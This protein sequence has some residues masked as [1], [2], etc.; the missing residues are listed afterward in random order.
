MYGK[1]F[2]FIYELE[3]DKILY[4]EW[5][6]EKF[7]K[8]KDKHKFMFIFIS[9]INGKTN[10][11]LNFKQVADWTKKNKFMYNNYNPEIIKLNN[12]N[13]FITELNLIKERDKDVFPNLI[14]DEYVMTDKD[15]LL[16]MYSKKRYEICNI[17]KGVVII[18]DEEKY[19]EKC[20]SK[21]SKELL[22]YEHEEKLKI[23]K[24]ENQVKLNRIKELDPDG[25]LSEFFNLI[26]DQ[27]LKS[28][29]NKILSE[30]EGLKKQYSE[31]SS[32]FLSMSYNFGMGNIKTQIKEVVNKSK[33][34]YLISFGNT[35]DL[36]DGCSFILKNSDKK[37]NLNDYQ[38]CSYG[39]T[40]NINQTINKIH[41]DVKSLSN[42]DLKFYFVSCD[43]EILKFKNFQ[44][45][46]FINSGFDE[47]MN[48]VLF[49][50]TRNTY[51]DS[52]FL[53]SD[54]I[55]EFLKKMVVFEEIQNTPIKF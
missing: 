6:Y 43:D 48:I 55:F 37:I 45:S 14:S 17:C 19:C 34:I 20:N 3:I 50:A 40:D 25:K 4:Y 47:N 13:E 24:L 2:K 44:I 38:I 1:Y 29:E 33:G 31:I 10:I 36:I 51:N 9:H 26:Y 8:N 54:Y 46:S 18:F 28:F 16:E 21:K 7:V 32:I 39:I 5:F 30:I 23:S 49:D 27:R 15:R 22:L 11:L 42:I 52:L 53:V 35:G 12:E 41:R